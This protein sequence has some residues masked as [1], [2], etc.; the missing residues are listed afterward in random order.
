M[1]LY[2]GIKQSLFGHQ[3]QHHGIGMTRR[4]IR[5][6]NAINM[7]RACDF[8]SMITQNNTSE[9][10]KSR[11]YTYNPLIINGLKSVNDKNSVIG[12]VAEKNL[13]F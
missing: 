2:S 6:G 12:K 3:T 8:T 9:H 7:K 4:F 10:I 1:A 11:Q 13:V 5:Y